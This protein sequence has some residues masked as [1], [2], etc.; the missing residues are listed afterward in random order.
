MNAMKTVL[1]LGI[2]LVM[3]C[4]GGCMVGPDYRAPKMPV[5]SHWS[6]SATTQPSAIL[7]E[8]QQIEQWWTTF[9]DPTLD[10]LI[11]RAVE[12]NLDVEIATQRIREARGSLGISTAGL[13]PNVDANGSYTHSG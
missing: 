9:D 2:T 12:S 10:G 8:T 4:L 5:P 7:Q 6:V 3:L 11:R 1:V 13:F